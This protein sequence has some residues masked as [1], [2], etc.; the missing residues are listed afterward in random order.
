MGFYEVFRYLLFTISELREGGEERKR[1]RRRKKKKRGN[2][3]QA[4]AVNLLS[5]SV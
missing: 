3:L 2:F 4:S 5:E 1:K